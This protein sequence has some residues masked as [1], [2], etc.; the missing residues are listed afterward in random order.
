MTAITKKSNKK[1]RKLL[2]G[3]ALSWRGLIPT[4][5]VTAPQLAPMAYMPRMRRNGQMGKSAPSAPTPPDPVA[6]AEAQALLTK[7]RLLLKRSLNRVE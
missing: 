3:L 5:R 4:L 6:T 7:K 2:T 1:A